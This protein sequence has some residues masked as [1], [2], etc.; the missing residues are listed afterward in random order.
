M[1]QPRF[2]LAGTLFLVF[3]FVF[4]A[5][6]VLGQCP[7]GAVTLQTQTQVNNFATTYPSCTT[8]DGNL[9]IQQ[10]GTS[11]QITDISG[12]SSLT[13][14]NGDLNIR[15]NP[16]LPNLTGLDN[17]STVGGMLQVR[18]NDAAGFTSLSGL[19]GLTSVG[20][21]VLILYN[22]N[23]ANVNALSSLTHIAGK[24]QAQD[25]PLLTSLT[26][27]DNVSG[28]TNLTI[29][30]NAALSMCHVASVCSFL[31]AGG[32]AAIWANT[33]DCETKAKVQAACAALPIILTNFDASQ[34]KG[35]VYL[36][37]VTASEYNNKG[38]NIQRSSDG[39]SWTDI[40]FVEGAGETSSA[41]RYT[42]LDENARTGLNYY[43]LEQIDYDGQVGYSD[44][45]TV[46]LAE[47]RGFSVYPNPAK[48]KIYFNPD[49]T[50][51]VRLVNHYGRIVLEAKNVNQLDVSNLPNGIYE[52]VVS[53]GSV[54]F[55]ENIVVEK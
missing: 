19:G 7:P 54:V 27:L 9:I 21:D 4:F 46:H 33:G 6:I 8:I 42:Y 26:G 34:E 41:I 53:T 32:S 44:M 23:L 17:I 35:Q 2:A 52:L 11:D 37:W 47:K 12:L 20:T 50:G 29:G 10:Q 28:I 25:N 31:D 13:T 43:R 5:N 40:A 22:D 14:I 1:N 39:R 16:S 45:V 55:A 51:V 24:I 15:D 3:T 18:N 48:N 36:D 38:F 49:D 30:S